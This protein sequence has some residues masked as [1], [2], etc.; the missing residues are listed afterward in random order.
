MFYLMMRFIL[1]YLRLYLRLYLFKALF[2]PPF[3]SFPIIFIHFFQTL[4]FL[5]NPKNFK[6]TLSITCL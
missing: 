1:I 4:K 5:S 3:P 6:Q 2:L